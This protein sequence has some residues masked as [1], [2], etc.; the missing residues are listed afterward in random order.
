MPL[1]RRLASVAALAAAVLSA[2][3]LDVARAA[4]PDARQAG[5][6]DVVAQYKG[7]VINL[8]RDGWGGAT[9][10]VEI[11]VGDVRCF[12]SSAEFRP[13]GTNAPARGDRS[14][15]RLAVT[16]DCPYLYVCAYENSNFT[17]RRLAFQSSGHKSFYT[18]GF[19][20]KTTSIANLKPQFGA[21]FCKDQFGF[22]PCLY[23]GASSWMAYI[24]ASYNDQVDYIEM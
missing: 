11:K 5:Q 16:P 2:G 6:G 17:G 22:D 12:D 13:A 3:S 20:D 19:R 4:S 14:A 9:S 10:C 18:Y 24:G 1:S 21:A 15:D 8:T 23:L 7:R